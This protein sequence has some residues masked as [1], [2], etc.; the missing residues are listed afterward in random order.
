MA[1]LERADHAR[2]L[3]VALHLP[4]DLGEELAPV[5]PQLIGREEKAGGGR[6][7]LERRHRCR[8]ELGVSQVVRHEEDE[9]GERVVALGEPVLEQV[10]GVAG[11]LRARAPHREGLDEILPIAADRHA[12]GP[13]V[14]HGHGD[15]V[16]PGRRRDPVA[17][18]ELLDRL[19]EPLPLEVGL[20]AGE[21]EEGRADIVLCQ[22]QGE[23]GLAKLG[24]PGLVEEQH[25]APGAIVE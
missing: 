24:Q 9:P 4:L 10:Q 1:L 22:P 13:G 6:D 7:A 14:R 15:R 19:R 5:L 23:R 8:G 12:D 25:G 16:H 21:E 18:D 2:E 11:H 20:V 17:R 3:G